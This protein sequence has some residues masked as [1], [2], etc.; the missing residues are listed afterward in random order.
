MLFDLQIAGFDLDGTIIT[1]KSGKSFA[2]N[3]NDWKCV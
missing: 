1:T 2:T 3:V